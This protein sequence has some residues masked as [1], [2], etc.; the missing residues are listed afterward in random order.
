MSHTDDILDQR[1]VAELVKV[2]KR[3]IQ[4]WSKDGKIPVIRIAPRVIRYSRSAILKWLEEK[5][6]PAA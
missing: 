2:S 4:S 1:G 6:Q 5:S 3:T